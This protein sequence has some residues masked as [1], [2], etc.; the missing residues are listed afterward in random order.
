MAWRSAVSSSCPPPPRTRGSSGCAGP[1]PRRGAA[2]ADAWHAVQPR[3]GAEVE[4]SPRQG[5]CG[6]LRPSGAQPPAER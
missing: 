4:A 3:C 5:V 2:P 6:R 1:A